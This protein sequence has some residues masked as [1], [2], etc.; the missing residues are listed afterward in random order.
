MGNDYIPPKVPWGAGLTLPQ[1]F[2]SVFQNIKMPKKSRDGT[3]RHR[4]IKGLLLYLARSIPG[5]WPLPLTP[6]P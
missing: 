4:R 2:E 5:P 6:D 1:V 3:E